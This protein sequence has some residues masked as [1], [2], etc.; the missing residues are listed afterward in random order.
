MSA[1]DAILAISSAGTL[2]IALL[3]F[4][5]ARAIRHTAWLSRSVALWQNFNQ[6][7]MDENRASRWAGLLDGTIPEAE[8]SRSDKHV[9]FSYVNIIYLE[10][11][12]ATAG[13]IDDHYAQ[14]SIN[15]N[16][17]QLRP[18]RAYIAPLL[19]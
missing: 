7:L 11:R 15:G 1:I 9:L 6:L 4:L 16:L 3:V 19:R 12:Y 8:I 10:Y 2:I 18:R 17:Q 5:E 13:L 14:S